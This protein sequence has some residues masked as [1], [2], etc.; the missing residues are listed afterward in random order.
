[1]FSKDVGSSLFVYL[2]INIVNHYVNNVKSTSG[3]TI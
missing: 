1:M 3:R 2:N